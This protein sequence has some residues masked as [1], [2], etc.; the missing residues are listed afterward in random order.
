MCGA[1][2]LDGDTLV[3]GAKDE[4]SSATSVGGP[5]D[6]DTSESSGAAYVFERDAG[7]MWSQRAYLKATNTD[8]NDN[9]GS[10]MALSD[11]TLVIGARTESSSATG[12]NGLQENEAAPSSGAAY[13]YRLAP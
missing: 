9:F 1:V 11:G 6:D 10:P 7:G 8:E 5:Q 13:I 12:V 4:S 3:V 2:A